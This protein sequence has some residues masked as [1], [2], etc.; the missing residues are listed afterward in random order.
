MSPLERLLRLVW[1]AELEPALRPLI[2][3]SLVSSL[4]FSSAYTFLGI[5]ALEKLGATSSQLGVTFLVSA[6]AGTVGGYVG[7]HLSDRV[8]RRPLIL[9]GIGAQAVVVL[10]YVAAGER[11]LLGLGVIVL[12]W[13]AA[14][15]GWGVSQAFVADLVSP[16]D[17]EA[18]YAAIRVAQNLGVTLGPPVGGL[19]LAGD[20]WTRLFC[21][22]SA[23]LAISFFVAWRLLPARGEFSPDTEPGVS[24]LRV[25]RN[26]RVFL[27]FV[28]SGAL[29]Y[30]VYV[31]YEVALPISAV[32]TY[33]ISTTAWGF[34]FMINPAAVTLFQLRLT[35]RAERF[36]VVPKLVVAMLLMGFPFLILSVDHSVPVFALVIAIFVV[37]EMLWIPTSQAIVAGLAPDRLR[38]A[39]MGA[40][41]VTSAV[42]F[43]LGPFAA[44][45]LRDAAGDTA[46]WSFFACVSVVAAATG[47]VAARVALGRRP[48]PTVP[49]VASS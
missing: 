5:W 46:M 4:A 23:L 36:P 34:L 16:K 40:F 7:G 19:L 10:G 37:G 43:A 39:Y 9:L 18:G 41:G 1:G 44:L 28:V 14:S 49:S 12:S 32:S 29:A 33:D 48:L 11:V 31:G 8:G 21:A 26:D 25:I 20:S 22:V 27:L 24:S 47:A 45:Q 6:V 15:I 30:L 35:R 13:G 38:G 42:G 17:R 2:A 3:V